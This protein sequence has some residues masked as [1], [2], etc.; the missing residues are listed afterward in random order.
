M[1]GKDRGILLQ[2]GLCQPY[3]IPN[4]PSCS[5][6]P[7]GGWQAAQGQGRITAY[8]GSHLIPKFPLWSSTEETNQCSSSWGSPATVNSNRDWQWLPSKTRR[9]TR[10]ASFPL[11]RALPALGIEAAQPTCRRPLQLPAVPNQQLLFVQV[12]SYVSS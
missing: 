3:P 1:E 6:E 10:R 7:V 4:M 2:P 5:Q 8:R 9:V 12:F 11:P